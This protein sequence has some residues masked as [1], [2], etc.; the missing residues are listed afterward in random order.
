[1]RLQ[2]LLIVSII[3]TSCAPSPEG[4]VFSVASYN[5][6][7]LFDGVGDGDEFEGFRKADGYSEAV[8]DE[9][10]RELAMMLGRE[11]DADVIILEEVES[12]IVL[13]DL[14]ERGLGRK[15]Y[16]YYGLASDGGDAVNVGFVSRLE[17][18]SAR[19]HSFEGERPMLE[20]TFLVAGERVTVFGVH[21]RSRLEDGS[22]D[23]RRGQLEHLRS[24]ISERDD[25]F[26][27]VAGDFN[28]D[29]RR[30]GEPMSVYPDALT[31]ET[32]IS[33]SADPGRVGIGVMYAPLLDEDI[34]FSSPG[35]YFYDGSWH[36]YDSIIM[37][38][39]A[40]DGNALEFGS[41][42]IVTSF[43]LLDPLSRPLRFDPSTGRGFSDHLPVVATFRRSR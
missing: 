2:A 12:E 27:I 3:L 37:G 7:C 30:S 26:V 1:M 40:I 42:E 8:Y 17:P 31:E 24:L 38:K 19:I 13:M 21:L 6:Y 14:I 4:A 41:I 11:V 20:L 34:P 23:V 35:T 32:V 16:H 9:R 43:C 39:D 15:G 36:I 29:P 28:L 33:L 22:D 10:I 5:A 25:S 18:L